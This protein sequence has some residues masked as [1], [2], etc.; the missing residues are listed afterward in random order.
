MPELPEVETVRRTLS[1]AIIGQ[2]IKAID[3]RLVKL[4][5][6]PRASLN[7]LVG[8]RISSLGR[9]AKMLLVHFDNGSSLIIH[10]KMTGQL[11]YQPKRGSLRI[12]GHPIPRGE[13]D[14]PHRHTHAIF[15][16][17]DGSR[18]FYNDLRKFG[19]FRGVPTEKLDALFLEMKLGPEPLAPEFTFEK[20]TSRLT[21]RAK[22]RIKDALLDQTVLAGLGNIYA[23]EV[24]YQARLHP[25]RRVQ[26]VSPAERRRLFKAIQRIVKLAIAQSGTTY[27]SFRDGL[28]RS[29]NMLNYL[30]VYQ[31]TGRPCRRCQTP[32]QRLKLGSRSAHFCPN[33]QPLKP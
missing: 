28:G 33:C 7:R 30:K 27:R 25:A 3:L 23:D 16:F 18:L 19:Y 13:Q 29:G 2:R 11:I 1:R 24:N 12:G 5:K 8:S 9:R 17:S 21:R 14:L 10:L 4:L 32:I 31:R 22:A 6:S 26:T 15:T 20:F